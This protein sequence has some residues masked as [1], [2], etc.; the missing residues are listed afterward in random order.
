RYKEVAASGYGLSAGCKI[1]L[2]AAQNS[3]VPATSAL[4]ADRVGKGVRV[5]P[6]DALISLSAPPQRLGSAFGVH[7]A[8]DTLGALIGPVVAFLVLEAAPKAYD[9]VFMISF[10]FA[11][12]GLAILVLFVGNRRPRSSSPTRPSFREA[13]RLLRDR[14]FRALAISGSLV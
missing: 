2:L 3:P 14:D 4:F 12:L 8:F 13:M 1:G 10:L 6:R 5:A 7:R 11:I 9:A